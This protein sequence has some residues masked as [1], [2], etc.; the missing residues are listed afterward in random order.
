MFSAPEFADS[1]G[2]VT[3]SESSQLSLLYYLPS[4]DVNVVARVLFTFSSTTRVALLE[5]TW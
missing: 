5:S 2:T 1:Y 4:W 3:R